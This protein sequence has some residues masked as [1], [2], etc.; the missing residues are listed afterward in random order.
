MEVTGY[1]HGLEVC[2]TVTKDQD[3]SGQPLYE[4]D[5]PDVYSGSGENIGDLLT[6]KAIEDIQEFLIEIAISEGL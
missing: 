1:F 3:G 5:G 2:G 6:Y 4:I